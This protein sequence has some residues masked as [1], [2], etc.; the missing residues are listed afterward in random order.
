MEAWDSIS[1]DL[2][3][4]CSPTI[5][6]EW[7]RDRDYP[8]DYDRFGEV[9]LTGDPHHVQVNVNTSRPVVYSFTRS[10]AKLNGKRYPQLVYVWWYPFHPEMKK[11]DP[12]A[13]RIN[14][15]TL[16]ITLDSQDR[17]AVFEVIQSCGCGHL[18]F[19]SQQLE[20]QA[21][22]EFGAPE[23]GKTLQIRR[24]TKVMASVT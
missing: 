4:R 21:K 20:E 19:V 8:A 14:G 12:A 15:D 5:V 23:S 18:I 11:D 16:R 17:P 6:I 13:G 22:A 24:S 1:D 9:Y 10:E 2:P 7:A 3:K